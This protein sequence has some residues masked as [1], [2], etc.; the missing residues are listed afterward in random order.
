M[1]PRS[2]ATVMLESLWNSVLMTSKQI[3]LIDSRLYALNSLKNE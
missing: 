2:A 1:Q 3:P